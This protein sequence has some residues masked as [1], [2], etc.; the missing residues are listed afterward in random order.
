[1]SEFIR[2]NRYSYAC[3]YLYGDGLLFRFYL[4]LM[5]GIEG[6]YI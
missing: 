1:M 6:I 2:V 4:V 3:C 5:I